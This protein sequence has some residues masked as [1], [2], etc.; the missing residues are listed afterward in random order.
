MSFSRRTA[1]RSRR[2]TSGSATGWSCA[3]PHSRARLR[4]RGVPDRHALGQC[5]CRALPRGGFAAFTLKDDKGRIVWVSSDETFDVR[6]LPVAAA[7]QAQAVARASTCAVGIVTPIP[8]MNDG[9]VRTCRRRAITRSAPMCRRSSRAATGFSC[10]SA[11]ATAPGIP[12]P[13]RDGDGAR[14]YRL[15]EIVVNAHAE[16]RTSNVKSGGREGDDGNESRFGSG[17]RRTSRP[18]LRSACRTR[19]LCPHSSRIERRSWRNKM[20]NVRERAAGLVLSGR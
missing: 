2:S 15:G 14:R 8:V 10:R 11:R 6:T 17:T 20:V 13:L 12:L 16:R 1:R 5:R 9:V 19:C 4:W 3:R 18:R 7:G